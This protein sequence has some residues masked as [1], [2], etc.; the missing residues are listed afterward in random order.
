MEP[1]EITFVLAVIGAISVL[2]VALW[3]WSSAVDGIGRVRASKKR[4]RR[5]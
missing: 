3:I 4:G 1:N 2:K 5:R